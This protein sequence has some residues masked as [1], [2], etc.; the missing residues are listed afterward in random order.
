MEVI[1][2]INHD[3][4]AIRSH[5][6][7]YPMCKHSTEDIRS[8]DLT[9]LVKLVK[10]LRRREPNCKIAIWASL[11]CTNFS[12][13]KNGPKVADSRTLALD[14]F[15]YLVLIK[16]DFFWVE[17]VVEFQKWGPLDRFN[18]P[19]KSKEGEDYQKW[20]KTLEKA[21]PF[22]AEDVLISADFG[23]VTIRK[24]L[25]LQFSVDKNMIGIPE[26]THCKH[27][28]G[29][30]KWRA[31]KEVL[32]LDNV[33]KS[34]FNRKRPLVPASHKRIYS[35]LVK[36]G[37]SSGTNWG[38]KYYGQ[39]GH[40]DMNDPSAT[41]TTKDRISPVHVCIKQDYGN[42]TPSSLKEPMKTLTT[43]PKGDLVTAFVTN[44]QY[45]GS[46]RSVHEPAAT[47][48]ARQDKAPLGLAQC[49]MN[50]QTLPV[51]HPDDDPYMVLIKK[52]CIEHNITDILIRPL[53]VLEMLRIQGFPG[54]YRLLGTKTEQKKHIGN[55]VEVKVGV[56]LFQSID[57]QIQK[58]AA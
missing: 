13:A 25:F 44:P 37:P 11:E 9:E 41:L 16:P 29:L 23:G 10:T 38:I 18:R 54:W 55:S 50:G 45:G 12:N 30:P 1:W 49:A 42:S 4:T 24:R 22:T 14:M 7:N 36:F 35:G 28:D 20:V 6:E 3:S 56:A 2:C 51:I 21:F 27:G 17:N 19:I 5:S 39:M 46:N 34:I 15:R 47:A 43:N 57:K 40:Q 33:G 31:V 58:Y 52:Y 53:T 26:Q 48:I 8:F 32:E